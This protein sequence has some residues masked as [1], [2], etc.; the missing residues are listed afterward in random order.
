[1]GLTR[2]I[3]ESARSGIST[4]LSQLTSLVIV[5]DEELSQVDPA[6]LEAELKARRAGREARPKKPEDNPVA[7]IAG[8]SEAARA[9]RVKLSNDRAAKI[10][11]ERSAREARDKAAADEAFRRMKEQAASGA[12]PGSSSSHG[13]G[14]R[15][16]RSGGD[17]QVAEWY[18][19]LDLQPGADLAAIKSAYRKLM[20]KYHP[21]LHT[22]DAR[23]QKAATE[24]SMRVTNAY[25]GLRAHL[26]EK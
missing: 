21:D 18:R 3:L 22:G 1:M 16:G 2:R 24:L 8:A 6:A 26:G 4:G 7:R 5:D 23:K 12:R 20:R 11:Q 10:H 13:G 17:P 25:N 15:P 9:Q 19:V 14:G